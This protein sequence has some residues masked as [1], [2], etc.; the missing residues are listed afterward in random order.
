MKTI[1]N[2]IAEC[3]KQATAE[4]KRSLIDPDIS[5]DQKPTPIMFF[6]KENVVINFHESH[7]HSTEEIVYIPSHGFR[8]VKFGA[9]FDWENSHR[10]VEINHKRI[11]LIYI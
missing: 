7:K 2:C 5:S 8:R 6:P 1:E 11:A 3:R 10:Y 4:F 9:V